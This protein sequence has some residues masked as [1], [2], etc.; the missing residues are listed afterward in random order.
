MT[1]PTLPGVDQIRHRA[2]RAGILNGEYGHTLPRFV[3]D[4]HEQKPSPRTEDEAQIT[5]ASCDLTANFRES[6]QQSQ[7]GIPTP[8]GTRR[9]AVG[10]DEAIEPLDPPR[11]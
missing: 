6:L 3:I 8:V 10:E 4:V 5:P 2:R 9:R 11:G 7:R 1:A